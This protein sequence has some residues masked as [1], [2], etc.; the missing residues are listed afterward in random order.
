MKPSHVALAVA[1]VIAGAAMSYHPRYGTIEGF[2][3]VLLLCAGMLSFL[4]G[5]RFRGW[6]SK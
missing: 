2:I 6:N 5:I 3:G 4:N 1:A